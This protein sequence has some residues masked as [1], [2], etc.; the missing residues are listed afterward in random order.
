MN[1]LSGLFTWLLIRRRAAT[2]ARC[3]A[4]DCAALIP[5]VEGQR[6]A[7]EMAA[8]RARVAAVGHAD[9]RWVA[10]MRL[11]DELD[12]RAGRLADVNCLAPGMPG[13]LPW[14]TVRRG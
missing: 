4:S 8:A 1:R 14:E 12:Q 6:D 2:T 11:G 3:T 9:A 5:Y 13:H 10:L 7:F